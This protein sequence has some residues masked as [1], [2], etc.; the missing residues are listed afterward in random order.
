MSWKSFVIRIVLMVISVC[1][2]LYWAD[3]TVRFAALLVFL[4]VLSIAS[5]WAII[6]LMKDDDP[7]T[8]FFD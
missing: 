2:L 3:Q 5:T 4:L 7:L 6:C 8:G 1:G